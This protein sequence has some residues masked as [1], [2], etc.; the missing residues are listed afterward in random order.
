M[1]EVGTLENLIHLDGE[2]SGD[3]SVA[4][5]PCHFDLEVLACSFPFSIIECTSPLLPP[6]LEQAVR[7]VDWGGPRGIA[8]RHQQPLHHCSSSRISLPGASCGTGIFPSST[9]PLAAAISSL[10]PQRPRDPGPH[11]QPSDPTVISYFLSVF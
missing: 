11:P 7:W 10:A 1:H 3:L 9:L 2:I 8:F 4:V 6:N 5:S